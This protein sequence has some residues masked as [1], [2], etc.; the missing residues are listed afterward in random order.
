M[1]GVWAA[2]MI[3]ASANVV[4]WEAP[5]GC[6]DAVK[7]QAALEQRL[8]HSLDDDGLRLRGEV[9]IEEGGVARLKLHTVVEGRT[10]TRTLEAASCD[11]LI[12]AAVVV[13]ALLVSDSQSAADPIAADPVTADP[14]TADPQSSE[15]ASAEGLVVEP[16]FA[17]P[18]KAQH[19]FAESNVQPPR[20]KEPDVVEKQTASELV[21]RSQLDFALG[22]DAGVDSSSTPGFAALV[23]GHM[24]LGGTWARGELRGAYI[25]PRTQERDA[26]GL[27][28]QLGA[29]AL[30]GCVTPRARKVVVPLCVGA[31]AGAMRGRPLDVDRGRVGHAPWLAPLGAAGV[32]V[33]LRGGWRLR[34]S[35]ELAVPLV[36]PQFRV[37][38]PGPA[39]VL[40][41]PAPA[42]VRAVLGV[43]YAFVRGS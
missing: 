6:G 17:E 2:L 3:V 32:I 7:V 9:S 15:P 21:T 43:E 20:D 40:F 33:A 42:S 12:E 34:A 14:V 23:R 11:E 41:A 31:E 13:S 8:G 10:D 1:S 24:S 19:E 35:A 36:R 39:Q 16:E 22:L 37:R 25:T 27:R 38:D 5:A 18:H 29:V 4:Q 26:G 30:L 28:A